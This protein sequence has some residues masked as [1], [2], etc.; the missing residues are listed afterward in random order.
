MGRVGTRR[1]R[2]ANRTVVAVICIVVAVALV[3]TC[4]FVL[5]PQIERQQ[6]KLEYAGLIEQYAGQY[7]LEDVYKRQCGAR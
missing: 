7:G 2:G 4:I 6:Y 3:L 1:P 5:M